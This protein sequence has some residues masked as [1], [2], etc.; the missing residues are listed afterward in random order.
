MCLCVCW[1][2]WSVSPQVVLVSMVFLTLVI[3]YLK[4]LFAARK[5]SGDDQV[6][7]LHSC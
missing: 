2:R 6:C 7:K 3:T 1:G 4:V 5:A